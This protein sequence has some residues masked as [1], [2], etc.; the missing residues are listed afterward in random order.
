MFYKLNKLRAGK[1]DELIKTILE[2][3][4]I[5]VDGSERYESMVDHPCTISLDDGLL[6][7]VF[8]YY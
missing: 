8:H 4:G 2:C 1:Y 6:V 7:Y 5:M 3:D